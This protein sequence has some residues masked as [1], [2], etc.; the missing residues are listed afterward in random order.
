MPRSAR[1]VVPMVPHHLIQR[2]NRRQNVFFSDEDKAYYVRLLRQWCSVRGVS[3][4][5]YCLMDNYVHFVAVP[6]TLASLAEAFGAVHQKYT[7]AIN[8][9]YGWHGFLWQGRFLSFPLDAR[10][11]YR[12]IR[13]VE[14]NP[15]RAKIVED[16][17][18]YPWS[19]APAHVLGKGDPLLSRNPLGM[20]RKG[21]GRISGGGPD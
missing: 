14:L 20:G 10:Y 11:L 7:K 16:A 3:I 6:S 15:V 1:I 17:S 21:V 18:D 5:A 2:G 12:A 8:G 19:S 4:W 9:R 13:Y